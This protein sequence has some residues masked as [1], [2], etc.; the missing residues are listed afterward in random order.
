MQLQSCFLAKEQNNL[1]VGYVKNKA[2]M[3]NR[4]GYR[5]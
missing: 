4:N 3:H 1:K 5:Q 2:Y